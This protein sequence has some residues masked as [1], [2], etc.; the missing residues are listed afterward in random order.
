MPIKANG[1]RL[2]IVANVTPGASDR[3]GKATAVR[4]S[5]V[6]FPPQPA[7]A[8]LP[9]P[10][11]RNLPANPG[12]ASQVTGP[13]FRWTGAA[14]AN[15]VAILQAQMIKMSEV[16]NYRSFERPTPKELVA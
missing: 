16:S 13:T 8:G 14:V 3:V 1:R 12:V 7:A 15:P 10:A 11:G 5:Q 6:S 4:R 2:Q 9:A